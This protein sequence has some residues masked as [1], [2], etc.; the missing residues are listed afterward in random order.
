MPRN[1][2]PAKDAAARF[3]RDMR[4]DGEPRSVP[5]LVSY[6]AYFEEN[7]REQ[8][9]ADFQET[10][11]TETGLRCLMAMEKAILMVSFNAHISDGAL[12]EWKGA[13]DFVLE[14]RRL[15]SNG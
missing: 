11:T 1:S 7:E 9:I 15:V 13:R 4:K 5:S 14:L 2:D 12:R 10:F 3:L 6:L 8:L